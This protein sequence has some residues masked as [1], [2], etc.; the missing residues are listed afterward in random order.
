MLLHNIY[1]VRPLRTPPKSVA[2]GECQNMIIGINFRC[3]HLTAS[4]QYST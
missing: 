3:L 4:E 1:N 2:A